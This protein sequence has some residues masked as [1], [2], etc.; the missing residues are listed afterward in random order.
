MTDS[1]LRLTDGLVE[2]SSSD[3]QQVT[4]HYDVATGNY[5]VNGGGRTQVF[6]ARDRLAERIPGEAQF[7][8]ANEFGGNDY[9]TLAPISYT[10]LSPNKYVAMGYWQDNKPGTGD[11]A[12]KF[13][14]FTY[15]FGTPAAA[16]PRIG[17][18]SYA[19][20][21]FGLLTTPGEKA[22]TFEGPGQFD[23]DFGQGIFSISGGM[24]E[25][26][27]VGSG[28]QSTIYVG[29]GGDLASD[30]SFSGVFD[31][32]GASGSMQG[33][34]YGPAAEELGA[35]FLA[36][37]SIGTALN[38]AMT[39]R[40]DSALSPLN[41]LTLLNITKS[42]LFE[43]WTNAVSIE[44]FDDGTPTRGGASTGESD[45]G[46]LMTPGGP[47][48]LQHTIGGFYDLAADT[49]QTRPNFTSYTGTYL[50][51]D[52]TTPLQDPVHADFYNPGSSNS[53]LALT[54]TSFASWRTHS[55]ETLDVGQIGHRDDT[56]FSVFGI[57]PSSTFLAGMT[58]TATYAGVAYGAGVTNG[59]NRY[60]IH[61]T[62]DFTVDF[63]GGTY[64]GSLQLSGTDATSAMRDFK[65]L[66]VAWPCGVRA[67]LLDSAGSSTQS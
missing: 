46:L 19:T 27:V 37:N 60:D 8:A 55:D 9:L 17:V 42:E 6:A 13:Y 1:L 15:G 29:G 51:Y 25:F 67:K 65:S 45:L 39:G 16:V 50:R 28:G 48:S 32:S 3:R 54:Y 18:A 38:G 52:G 61:G 62:S 35:S 47:V 34:F 36:S 5:T 56:Y 31:Y 59:G 7:Q 40:R 57:K 10:D 63:S 49:S 30:G 64:S 41:N 11:Q 14:T 22:R 2:S 53:E 58:G 20:D 44:A 66:A 43:T 23:V 33:S 12:T 26:D 24:Q 4:I 21:I